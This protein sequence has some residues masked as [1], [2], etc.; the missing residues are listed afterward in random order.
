MAA[1]LHPTASMLRYSMFSRALLVAGV[2]A[3][4]SCA[5]AAETVVVK[6]R[7]PVPLDTFACATV[8]RDSFIERVCHDAVEQYL[9]I[10]LNGTY[11]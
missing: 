8:D 2:Y 11:Y 10:K 1:S 7:G 6:Y 5:A 3:V 9:I 4:L